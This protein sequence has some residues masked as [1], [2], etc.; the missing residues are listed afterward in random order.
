MKAGEE[1]ACTPGMRH[2]RSGF[3][4]WAATPRGAPASVPWGS[5]VGGVGG[6]RLSRWQMAHLLSRAGTK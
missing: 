2:S 6:H 4:G 5:L 3:R 1:E